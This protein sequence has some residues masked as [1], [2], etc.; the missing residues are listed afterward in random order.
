[1]KFAVGSDIYSHLGVDSE[2][3]SVAKKSHETVN[4]TYQE[5][6]IHREGT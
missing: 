3:I 2:E 5:R 1:M 6:L 4:K